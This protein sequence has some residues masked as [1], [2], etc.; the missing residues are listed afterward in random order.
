M[1]SVRTVR[2]WYRLSFEEIRAFPALVEGP[3]DVA[4]EAAFA[5][6]LRSIYERHGP[7]VVTMA[8]GIFE[9]R[10]SLGVKHGQPLPAGVENG[11]Q[12]WYCGDAQ[13]ALHSPNCAGIHQYLDH[14]FTSRVGIRTLIA[15]QTASTCPG[16]SFN[17]LQRAARFHSAFFLSSAR[18][19]RSWL[20][21]NC[22][23]GVQPAAVC[24]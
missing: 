17:A 4:S 7:T 11:A 22:R 18:A 6:L 21:R 8:R 13:E 2:D 12:R 24:L 16:L 23:H 20:R 15:Q 14:F 5:D 9:F 3:G 10:R 19:T 1:P